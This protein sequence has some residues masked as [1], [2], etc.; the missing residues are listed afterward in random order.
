MLLHPLFLA[1]RNGIHLVG[2]ADI[3]PWRAQ[4]RKNRFERIKI[5]I[6]EDLRFYIFMIICFNLQGIIDPNKNIQK[7]RTF[8]KATVLLCA[9]RGRVAFSKGCPIWEEGPKL[10]GEFGLPAVEWTQREDNFD[11]CNSVNSKGGNAFDWPIWYNDM[12]SIL[13]TWSMHISWF[14]PTF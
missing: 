8:H 3:E 14:C 12:Y 1:S 9:R 2:N 5:K 11:C 10:L 4:R 13:Y 7:H 6:K